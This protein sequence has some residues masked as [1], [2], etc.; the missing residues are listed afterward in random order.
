MPVLPCGSL[1]LALRACNSGTITRAVT[2]QH[3][4]ASG[5]TRGHPESN[6]PRASPRYLANSLLPSNNH[7]TIFLP[8]PHPANFCDCMTQGGGGLSGSWLGHGLGSLCSC[9]VFFGVLG[10]CTGMCR[11]WAGG[12]HVVPCLKMFG[13][14][15]WARD[16]FQ[17]MPRVQ[18]PKERGHLFAPPFPK[19]R[20]PP[21][22]WHCFHLPCHSFL[23]HHHLARALWEFC[24]H[25]MWF[26]H[27][28]TQAP[29]PPP[30]AFHHVGCILK[31]PPMNVVGTGH[32]AFVGCCDDATRKKGGGMWMQKKRDFCKLFPGTFAFL[33]PTSP[34]FILPLE[35]FNFV[36]HVSPN[37]PMRVAAPPNR[38]GPL[39]GARL[40]YRTWALP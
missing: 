20:A 35:L 5:P 17:K 4:K 34:S 1:Q 8:S 19:M 15:E 22:L 31:T 21:P 39:G 6:G 29:L 36:C 25:V 16:L 13:G 11:G 9:F 32:S 30:L 3:Y 12:S 40:F 2:G 10:F 38:A 14:A 28:N 7:S 26:Y 33:Q 18:A 27:V 37:Y 23:S 24:V